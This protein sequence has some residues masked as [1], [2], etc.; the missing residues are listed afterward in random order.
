MRLEST[1]EHSTQ[2][3]KSLRER[4]QR[5]DSIEIVNS[6]LG[7]TGTGIVKM[8]AGEGKDALLLL[9][10]NLQPLQRQTGKRKIKDIGHGEQKQRL[11]IELSKIHIPFL[12]SSGC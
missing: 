9:M 4:R 6:V 12:S 2:I 5:T 8:K 10:V 1:S 7:K 11:I 3:P